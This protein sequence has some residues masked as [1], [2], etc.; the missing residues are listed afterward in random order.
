[1][2]N[3]TKN[4]E[5]VKSGDNEHTY[6]PIAILPKY[7]T[8]ILQT[9]SANIIIDDIQNFF[10]KSDKENKKLTLHY[11]IEGADAKVTLINCANVVCVRVEN[12]KLGDN[13]NQIL[14]LSLELLKK[15]FPKP[16]KKKNKTSTK[17]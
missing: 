6:F 1:M 2:K 7:N 5:L 13:L 16:E 3:D 10:L 14:K 17:Q 11:R 4:I 8:H 15:E 9:Q 12:G